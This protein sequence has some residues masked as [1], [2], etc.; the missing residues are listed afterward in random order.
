M[1]PDGIH[2]TAQ[3]QPLILDQVWTVLQPLLISY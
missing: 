2:P 3:A 1:L